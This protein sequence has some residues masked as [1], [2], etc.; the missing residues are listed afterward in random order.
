MTSEVGSRLTLPEDECCACRVGDV[1]YRISCIITLLA[2]ALPQLQ[3][4]SLRVLASTAPAR[5]ATFPD[6]PTA[7]ESGFAAIEAL[8]WFGIFLPV[9]C[10]AQTVDQLSQ[11]VTTASEKPAVKAALAKQ[12]YDASAVRGEAFAKLIREETERWGKV[13]AEAGFSHL[14]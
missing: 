2:N 1:R 9:Y 3:A 12:A 14:D 5:S 7:R 10:L 6:L 13:V 8:E 4:G 11:S